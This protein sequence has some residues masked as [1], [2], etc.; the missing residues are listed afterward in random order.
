MRIISLAFLL[1]ALSINAYAD[2]L[3]GQGEAIKDKVYFPAI[4]SIEVNVPMDLVLTEGNEEDVL[5]VSQE[6]ILKNLN[7]QF[8]DGDLTISGRKELCP[9]N[10]TVYITISKLTSLELNSK[11]NVTANNKLNGEDVEIEVNEGSTVHLSI[12]AEEISLD[13]EDGSKVTLAGETDELHVHVE[14]SGNA[15]TSSLE[16][17]SVYAELDGSGQ[18]TVNPT[19]SLEAQLNGSGKILY[20]NKPAKLEIEKDGTGSIIKMR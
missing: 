15:N 4:H 8:D 17:N 12:N 11:V 6:D 9:D 19:E 14:G 2:C 13:L 10:L 16:A 18:I 20:K 3:P 5:V 1:I 7:L